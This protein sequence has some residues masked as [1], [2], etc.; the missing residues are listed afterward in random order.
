MDPELALAFW[1]VLR[2]VRAWAETPAG[3]RAGLFGAGKREAWERLGAACGHA[4]GLVEALGTFALL[5]RAP[6]EVDARR[7]S[8]ACSQ[9]HAWAEERSLLAVAM[10]FAEAA[11]Y[12]D[13]DDP[14]RAN[15]AGRMCR[16]AA[17]DERASSWYHRG[18][19]LGVRRSDPTETIRAQIGYGNLMKDLGRHDEA[20]KFLERAARRA[21]YT[22]RKRQ[23]GEAHHDLLAIAAEVGTYSEAER[24]VRRAL[25]LY[26]T[27]HP[28]IPYLAHDFAFVLIRHQ[29]YSFAISLLNH[30]LPSI[31]KPEEL[32]LVYGTMARAA[33]GARHRERYEDA[34]ERALK[35]F[36]TH[37]EFSSATLIH[38]AEGARAFRKWDKSERYAALALEIARRRKESLLERDAADLESR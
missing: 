37:E 38:L 3:E 1:R 15:D 18:Y 26:P 7:L 22:G 2:R 17:E 27:H 29:Y 23:A 30:L 28:R 16:R 24:H 10:L 21:I 5:I 12:A 13:P 19:G 8:E 33:G 32:A 25:T 31:N 34:E 4:P 9:V 35:V 36:G 11:A 20:R 14:A 6:G